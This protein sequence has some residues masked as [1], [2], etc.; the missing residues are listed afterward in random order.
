ML[1]LQQRGNIE[2]GLSGDVSAQRLGSVMAAMSGAA[3]F[4]D[5]RHGVTNVYTGANSTTPLV[6]SQI[7][8]NAANAAKLAGEAARGGSTGRPAANIQWMEYLQDN[9]LS[10][11]DSLNFIKNAKTDPATHIQKLATAYLEEDVSGMTPREA[12]EKAKKDYEEIFGGGT[13]PLAFNPATTGPQVSL[14][15][16]MQAMNGQMPV[17]V[18]S[19]GQGMESKPDATRHKGRIILDQE[20][21]Q[22][23][24]SDGKEWITLSDN[25][26]AGA[27]ATS[28][29]NRRNQLIETLAD[30]V[31]NAVMQ[32]KAGVFEDMPASEAAALL[33][34]VYAKASI[35]DRHLLAPYL[36]S[37]RDKA[38]QRN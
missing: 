10:F 11:E 14:G 38:R 22:R 34:A 7:D 33:E 6:Q 35:F 16:A 31:G 2:R 28:V 15:D 3:P 23:F 30:D 36:Q 20:T 24:Q 18:P 26:P 17:V 9:G 27:Q 5:T 8:E 12:L 13:D 37:Y 25:A 1:D 29:E 19:K 21:G 32:I 4:A